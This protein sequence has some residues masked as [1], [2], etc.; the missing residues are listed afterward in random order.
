ML[1]LTLMAMLCYNLVLRH[2]VTSQVISVA[3]YIQRQKCDKFCSEALISA[4]KIRL[5]TNG[6]ASLS[7]EVRILRLTPA[8]IEPANLGS[9]GEYDNHWTTGST[10]MTVTLNVCH[11]G[12]Y[13]KYVIINIGIVSLL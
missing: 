10:L 2:S 5:G 6:F 13:G 8:G 12:D 4:V 9:S 1:V 3:F 7:K 11:G